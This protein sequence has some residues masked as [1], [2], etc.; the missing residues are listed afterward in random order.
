MLVNIE[1]LKKRTEK[2]TEQKQ[3]EKVL[4]EKY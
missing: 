2:L 1:F 3:M 4:I